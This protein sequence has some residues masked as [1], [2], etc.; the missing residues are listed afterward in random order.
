MFILRIPKWINQN[1]KPTY[2]SCSELQSLVYTL[3]FLTKLL[4][5]KAA[6]W[7]AMFVAWNAKI[8]NVSC[9]D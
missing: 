2:L 6:Y 7:L 9:G 4:L 3:I 5:L 8:S 1:L